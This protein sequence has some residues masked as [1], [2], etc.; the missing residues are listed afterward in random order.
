MVIQAFLQI[1]LVEINQGFC[2]SATWTGKTRKHLQRTKGL[3][4]FKMAILI[5]K[6]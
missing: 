2:D 4:R 5:E 1:P 3:R 6:D